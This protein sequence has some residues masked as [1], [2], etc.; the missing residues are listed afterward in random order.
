MPEQHIV[1]FLWRY[2]LSR[3]FANPVYCSVPANQVG[4]GLVTMAAQIEHQ[5]IRGKPFASTETLSNILRDENH[6]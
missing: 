5:D 4:P 1:D 6:R 3:Q 2:I